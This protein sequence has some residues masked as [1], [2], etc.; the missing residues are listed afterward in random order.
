MRTVVTNANTAIENQLTN[1]NS[2][3]ALRTNVK[4]R[5]HKTL[6]LFS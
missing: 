5:T 2:K 3:Y 6:L 4:K 1:E